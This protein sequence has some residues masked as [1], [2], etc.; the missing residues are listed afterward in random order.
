M[1]IYIYVESSDCKC[2]YY[3]IVTNFTFCLNVVLHCGHR[4]AVK[5]CP[6]LIFFYVVLELI[7]LD[8]KIFVSR[9]RIRTG[10]N[11]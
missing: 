3:F 1:V 11:N 5:T 7:I 2:S 4:R 8:C 10:M 9:K 6:S